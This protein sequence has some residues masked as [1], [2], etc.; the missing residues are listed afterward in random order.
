MALA[1]E[2]RLFL[3]YPM[4]LLPTSAA[5]LCRELTRTQQRGANA[6]AHEMSV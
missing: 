3:P 2:V 1:D 5:L 6:T 4:A